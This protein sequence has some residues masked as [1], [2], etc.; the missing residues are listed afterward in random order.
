MST[1][2]Q[3]ISYTSEQ[4]LVSEPTDV[5]HRQYFNHQLSKHFQKQILPRSDI[6]MKFP[7]ILY[8]ICVK[9][10]L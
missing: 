3:V 4:Q 5:Y 1:S 10:K 9:S 6:H 8:N 7:N 2:E